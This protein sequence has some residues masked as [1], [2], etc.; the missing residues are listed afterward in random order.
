MLGFDCLILFHRSNNELPGEIINKGTCLC[1]VLTLFKRG[2][3]IFN[4]VRIVFIV[5]KFW[6][7]NSF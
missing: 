7:L 1:S 3:R 4:K 6:M 5:V 2:S